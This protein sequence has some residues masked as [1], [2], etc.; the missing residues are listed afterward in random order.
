LLSLST[1]A[2]LEGESGS[3]LKLDMLCHT[4]AKDLEF[5]EKA[6]VHTNDLLM[7][8]DKIDDCRKLL[9]GSI[10]MLIGIKQSLGNPKSLGEPKKSISNINPIVQNNLPLEYALSTCYLLKASLIIKEIKPQ[11]TIE[12]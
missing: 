12:E 4:Y 1:I 5:I 10:S 11:G 3:A 6:I 7:E 8:F 2:Y 9:D